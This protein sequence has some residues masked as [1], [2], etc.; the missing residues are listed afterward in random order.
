M[1]NKFWLGL[2]W[3][4]LLSN[5]LHANEETAVSVK[6]TKKELRYTKPCTW[7]VYEQPKYGLPELV[8]EK[9]SLEQKVNLSFGSYLALIACPS[10]EGTLR[11]TQSFKLESFEREKLLAF[12]LV[13]AFLLVEI[14]REGESLGADVWVYDQW[15]LRVAAGIDKAYMVVPAEKLWIYASPSAEEGGRF[16]QK[17]IKTSDTVRL[18]PMQK[19]SLRLDITEATLQVRLTNN[20]RK[21][22]GEVTL[23]SKG[24]KS[25]MAW[26]ASEKVSVPPGVYQVT[27]Q[28]AEGHNYGGDKR[29][30]LKLKQGQH[31]NLT[32]QYQTE[33]L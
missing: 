26:D 23:L 31:H 12:N 13:P 17:K 22:P 5:A 24:G 15:G 7:S 30:A 27:A 8:S 9:N 19:K 10:S 16:D 14:L 33:Y 20:G 25:I 3:F 11:Q 4:I 28:L 6:V 18:S 1:K 32:L 2:L 21:S 29:K